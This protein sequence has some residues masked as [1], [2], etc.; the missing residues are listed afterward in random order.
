MFLGVVDY[1]GSERV[2]LLY[3]DDNKKNNLVYLNVK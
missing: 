3:F 1:F 2:I